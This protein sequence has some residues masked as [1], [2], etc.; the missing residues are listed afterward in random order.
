MLSRGGNSQKSNSGF[1]LI[2][3]ESD[4]VPTKTKSMMKLL[5]SFEKLESFVRGFHDFDM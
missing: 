3:M 5:F 2:L 1:S 4:E